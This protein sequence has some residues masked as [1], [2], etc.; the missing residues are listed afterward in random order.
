MM[1]EGLAIWG[2]AAVM[3]GALALAGCQTF[4]NVDLKG[5]QPVFSWRADA[6]VTGLMVLADADCDAV[7]GQTLADRV[8][9]RVE[10]P[11]APPVV[12]GVVPKGA[13]EVAPARPFPR[14]CGAFI[15]TVTDANLQG[16]SASF[17]P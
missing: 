17:D 7:H 9:W 15:V 8:W 4:V 14:N 10:G 3:A 12:Y 5:P 1:G 16:E 11:I 6:P 2:R 13:A